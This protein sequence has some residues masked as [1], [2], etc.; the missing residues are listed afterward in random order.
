MPRDARAHYNLGLLLQQ[1]GRLDEAERELRAALAE[2]PD[3]LEVLQAL[4]DY[5]LRRGRPAEALP[6]AGQMIAA[7]PD[8][9]VGHDLKALAERAVAAQR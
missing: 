3:S 4:A 7:H 5:L 2:E 6:L 8:E 1:L 9:R